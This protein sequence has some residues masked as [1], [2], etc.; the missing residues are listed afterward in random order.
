MKNFGDY[1]VYV[2]ES[3]DHE[4][5]ATNTDYPIFVLSF[6]IFKISDYIDSV[7]PKMQKI[8]F[9]YFGHDM[10]VFHEREIRKQLSPFEFLQVEDTR[11]AFHSELGKLIEDSPFTVVASVI[12]KEPFSSSYLSGLNPYHVALEFG[13]ERVFYHLQLKNQ[14]GK[15][16]F[17]V[18]EARGKK[19]DA[20]L[21]LEFRRILDETKTEGM[22]EMFKFRCVSKQVNSSGLQIADLIARPI[23][24]HVLNPEQRNRAWDGIEPKIR[25][26]P[27]GNLFGWGLKIYP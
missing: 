20:E 27:K 9:S 26:S 2:D 24:L 13:L 5:S 7:V 21:E 18:F 10:I 3:G 8:K 1:I 6:C 22:G 12:K 11:N 14:R 17:V 4:L 15:K 25:K 16:V 19:E 23:G